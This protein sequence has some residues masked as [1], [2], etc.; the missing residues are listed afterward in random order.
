SACGRC[1]AGTRPSMSAW[2][3]GAERGAPRRELYSSQRLMTQ[4]SIPVQDIVVLVLKEGQRRILS[5][6]ALFSMVAL[7][8]L[9]AGLNWPKKYSASAAIL[10][11][12][13]SSIAPVPGSSEAPPA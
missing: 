6:A 11:E 3:R 13:K 9:V 7:L 10:V 2:L 8:A 12:P 1:S 4:R 5:V